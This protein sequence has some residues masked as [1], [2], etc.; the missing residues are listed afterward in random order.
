MRKQIEFASDD[1]RIRVEI[2]FENERLSIMAVG[3]TRDGGR[4][5]DTFGGQSYDE[6]LEYFPK[7]ARLVEIW[8]RWHLNDL[9]AGDEVQEAYLRVHGRGK[10]YEET[11]AILERAGLLTHNG[12]RYGTA[13]KFEAVPSDIIKELEAM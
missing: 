7:S 8:R 6:L 4:W 2:K 12:Y 11:C 5:R 10:D 1:V 9:R 13:W 3:Y